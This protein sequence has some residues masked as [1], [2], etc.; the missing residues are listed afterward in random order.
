MVLSGIGANNGTEGETAFLPANSL[1]SSSINSKPGNLDTGS[2]R[3]LSGDELDKTVSGE[4]GS[5]KMNDK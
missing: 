4:F 3:K 1:F 5:L 2:N